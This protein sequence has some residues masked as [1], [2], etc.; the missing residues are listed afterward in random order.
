MTAKERSPAK[1]PAPPAAPAM[2]PV[3]LFIETLIATWVSRFAALFDGSAWLLAVPAA[4]GLWLLDPPMLKTLLQWS[5]YFSIMAAFVVIISRVA[6][7]QIK[8]GEFIESAKTG[9]PAAGMIVSAVIM[10][11]AIV[12]I[13]MAVWARPSG[14]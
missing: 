10:F 1:S 8:M 4:A 11:V 14:S 2:P 13:A 5:L 9:N 7:P 6:F 12:L 3:A